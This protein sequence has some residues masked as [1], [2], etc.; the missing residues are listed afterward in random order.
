MS[1]LPSLKSSNLSSTWHSAWNTVRLNPCL[2][3]KQTGC[4]AYFPWW[5]KVTI[6]GHGDVSRAYRATCSFWLFIKWPT[7]AL[8]YEF[9]GFTSF[10]Q[11]ACLQWF[12][13]FFRN[14]DRLSGGLNWG[15]PWA[16]LKYA[17]IMTTTS[18][19]V[20]S[21]YCWV[22]PW[23]ARQSVSKNFLWSY[24]PFGNCSKT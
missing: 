2:L 16:L 19:Q 4:W 11:H 12:L 13:T 5:L 23:L 6:P 10:H 8:P 20:P 7:S 15:I 1:Q 18:V 3:S 21:S 17:N 9:M 24:F 14:P 22:F